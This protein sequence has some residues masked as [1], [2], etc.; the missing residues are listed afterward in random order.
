MR[1][2]GEISLFKVD[3]FTYH[4][5]ACRYT[6]K[7]KDIPW[8]IFY[9]SRKTARRERKKIYDR[10]RSGSMFKLFNKVNVSGMRTILKEF[11]K[12]FDSLPPNELVAILAE[13]DCFEKRI[14]FYEKQMNRLGW[15]V[16]DIVKEDFYDKF[17]NE[18]GKKKV[19]IFRRY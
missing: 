17:G 19:L 9:L 2:F 5:G 13:D 15:L 12:Y 7:Q 18:N 11:K 1:R 4:I 6:Y 10:D 8:I 14:A 16:C 3:D